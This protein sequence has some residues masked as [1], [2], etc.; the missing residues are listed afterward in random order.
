[1]RIGAVRGNT[2]LFL[3]ALLKERGGVTRYRAR[4]APE[5]VKFEPKVM[6]FGLKLPNFGPP[7][8]RAEPQFVMRQ[9]AGIISSGIPR[10]PR[11]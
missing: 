1:V 4:P 2:L 3:I 7:S 6:K 11:R 8:A 5:V 10:R 9:E